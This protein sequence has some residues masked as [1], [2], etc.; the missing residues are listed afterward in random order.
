MEDAAAEMK[1]NIPKAFHYEYLKIVLP[2]AELTA[3]E[4]VSRWQIGEQPSDMNQASCETS[5]ITL[6][7]KQGVNG[8]LSKGSVV[9]VSLYAVYVILQN[10][11]MASK[12]KIKQPRASS[13]KK[14]SH[15]E[16][17]FAEEMPFQTA[18]NPK[19]PIYLPD[20]EKILGYRKS[21][22][23][24][25]KSKKETPKTV[26]RSKLHQPSK[27]DKNSDANADSIT[28]DIKIT[29]KET[30]P[31]YRTPKTEF[32]T[33]KKETPK[34]ISRPRL[35]QPSKED[36]IS[37][38]KADT[39]TE[40]IKL[41]DVPLL[42]MPTG[43]TQ[44]K[45]TR[46]P[47]Y[48]PKTPVSCGKHSLMKEA[49]INFLS[50]DHVLCE[51]CSHSMF[52]Y[53]SVVRGLV[54]GMMLEIVSKFLTKPSQ[55]SHC[56]KEN[57]SRTAMDSQ[58]FR[59]FFQQT[60]NN[61]SMPI[62]D[63]NV[64]HRKNKEKSN[65]E[66]STKHLK[67][68]VDNTNANIQNKITDSDINP[69]GNMEIEHSITTQ[70]HENSSRKIENT[71]IQ[72]KPH[73]ENISDSIKDQ[74]R[75]ESQ[76][77]SLETYQTE[78]HHGH[79]T[80]NIESESHDIINRHDKD[81]NFLHQNSL[82]ESMKVLLQESA[83]TLQDYRTNSEF[84]KTIINE[85]R[86][87]TED[88]RT[89]VE[90]ERTYMDDNRPEAFV[91]MA[92]NDAQALGAIV[93]GHSLH[94]VKTSK[95]LVVVITGSGISSNL[96]YQ[97]SQ[98]YHEVVRF[99]SSAEKKVGLLKDPE[100]GV[101][102][103][104]LLVWSLEQFSKCVYLDP[105][106]LMT[107]TEVS[108]Q[109]IQNCDELFEREELS[110]VPDIGWPDCFN[111]GVFVFRPSSATF[112]G[113]VGLAQSQGPLDGEYC[114]LLHY[115]QCL[116]NLPLNQLPSSSS[117]L[118]PLNH[119]K[120][121]WLNAC[122]TSVTGLPGIALLPK[123]S[124]W[125]PRYQYDLWKLVEFLLHFCH[126]GEQHVLNLYFQQF[127]SSDI[128]KKLPFLYNLVASVCYSYTPAFKKFGRDVKI[129]NFSGSPKPWGLQV[130]PA[131]EQLSPKADVHPSYV[132]FVRYW[133]QIFLRRCLPLAPEVTPLSLHPGLV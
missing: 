78:I 21:K 27:E 24:F 59:E 45:K 79:Y 39:I 63:Q 53:L 29:D 128:S 110:A 4:R 96:S 7:N 119:I 91:T 105:D 118:S 35:L 11:N 130:H 14:T 19:K 102:F 3:T 115:P 88:E 89:S 28:E 9:C 112:D 75:N 68:P 126:G 62:P 15:T 5:R 67:K 43:T 16:Q 55:C 69:S 42:E 87:S 70:H 109:V 71:T 25:V 99:P 10:N 129:V 61:E 76:I 47:S 58:H 117:F 97:L 64:Q 33:S 46:M 34:T 37:E 90:D 66:N 36:K 125:D 48:E 104:K 52:S 6:T 49:N 56:V 73:K 113:L 2:S 93:L 123:L 132:V 38:V 77:I 116:L 86:T 44:V 12:T 17:A 111:T 8:P 81:P 84:L 20:E 127:W 131:S 40:D 95:Q 120:L 60:E 50:T 80:E 74:N 83:Q 65:S 18:K 114:S 108:T 31:G 26:T 98:V 122:S 1:E 72:S 85:Y 103:E 22:E 57:I 133:L 107:N 124:N 54:D 23:E 101:T 30:L 32:V 92:A 106:I 94:L 13:K 100:L 51:K 121:T 41:P 82:D